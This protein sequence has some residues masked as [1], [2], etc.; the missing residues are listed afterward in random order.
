MFLKKLYLT[1]VFSFLLFLKSWGQPVAITN[2]TVIDGT[3]APPQTERVV[4][5]NE[6]NIQGISGR[7]MGTNRRRKGIG[8]YR[9][10][11]DTGTYQ[12]SRASDSSPG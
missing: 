4:V 6:G 8:P 9:S 3:G 10:L 5:V 1:S 2:V 7:I 11:Y 12:R